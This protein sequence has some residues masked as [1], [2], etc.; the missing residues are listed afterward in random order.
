M[1]RRWVTLKGQIME[2]LSKQKVAKTIG[3]LTSNFADRDVAFLTEVRAR[4]CCTRI[5]SCALHVVCTRA[6]SHVHCMWCTRIPSCVLH[7]VHARI[8]SCA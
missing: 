6:S 7:V 2:A 3:I 8:L 5:R 4:A 1:A